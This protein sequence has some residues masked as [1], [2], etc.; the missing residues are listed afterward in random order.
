MKKVIAS[1]LSLTIL[2]GSVRNISFAEETQTSSVVQ[3][4]NPQNQL[5]TNLEETVKKAIEKN[6][7]IEARVK[8]IKELLE[9]CKSEKNNL[10]KY[11]L[12]RDRIPSI[13]KEIE[14]LKKYKFKSEDIKSANPFE[15]IKDINNKIKAF[16]FEQQYLE[17]LLRTMPKPF[18]LRLLNMAKSTI[19]FT[20]LLSAS[21]LGD[22]IKGKCVDARVTY[23]FLISFIVSLYF[24]LSEE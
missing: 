18:I 11:E 1:I 7:H 24:E 22:F 17:I 20:L 14:G 6:P 15:Q 2:S 16:E 8:E 21:S 12:I 19:S 10:K 9:K 3:Q 13:I 23:N 4:K 5:D